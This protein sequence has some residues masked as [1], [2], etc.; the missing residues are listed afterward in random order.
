LE[1]GTKKKCGLYDRACFIGLDF[2]CFFVD[3]IK[4]ASRCLRLF[5]FADN[6]KNLSERFVCVNVESHL[7][8]P[9]NQKKDVVVASHKT[10]QFF[11]FFVGDLF[12]VSHT[13]FFRVIYDC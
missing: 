7:L 10:A 1:R 5:G 12:V 13:F 2:F 4:A 11:F 6:K 8:T 3:L 9:H